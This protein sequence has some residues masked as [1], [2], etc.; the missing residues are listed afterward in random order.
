MVIILIKTG[1]IKYPNKLVELKRIINKSMAINFK[2][3]I[4]NKPKMNFGS[5]KAVNKKP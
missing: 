4:L 1:E 3:N 2:S 5:I